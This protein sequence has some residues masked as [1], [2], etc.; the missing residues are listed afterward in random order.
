MMRLAMRPAKSD[1]NQ[2]T[3]WRAV[4]FFPYG[5]FTPMS[6]SVSGI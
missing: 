4:N 2:P 5:I 1:S 6:G 3:G